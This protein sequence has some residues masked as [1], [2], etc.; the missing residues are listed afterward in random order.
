MTKKSMQKKEKIREVEKWVE[1][2]KKWVKSLSD[3]ELF[4]LLP[5]LHE[6]ALKRA[7]VKES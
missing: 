7:K 4:V 3:E 6:E 5:L 1:N 2:L